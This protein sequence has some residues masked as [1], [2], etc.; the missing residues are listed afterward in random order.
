MPLLKYL[1]DGYQGL[2]SLYFV[3]KDGLASGENESS[4]AVS[5]ET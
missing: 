2:E 1:M 3:G 4:D 5:L